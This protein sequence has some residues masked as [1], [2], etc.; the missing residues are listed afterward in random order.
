[1]TTLP[2]TSPRYQFDE[3]KTF[4]Q[5]FVCFI[6]HLR[7]LSKTIKAFFG[8]QSAALSKWL[9]TSP[10]R[11]FAENFFS[12]KVLFLFQHWALSELFLSFLRKFVGPLVSTVF[13]LSNGPVCGE[14][15]FVQFFFLHHFWTLI[16]KW[17]SFVRIFF[18]QVDD[19]AFY[20]S[21]GLIWGLKAV[22]TN[23]CLF[24][25]S[26]ADLESKNQGFFSENNRQGCQNCSPRVHVDILQGFF[27]R[28]VFFIWSLG[29]DRHLSVISTKNCRSLCQYCF[30]FV[31]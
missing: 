4:W 26:F 1:M 18:G 22:L 14:K 17:S 29:I 21:K 10:M 2:F 20:G 15:K 28:K 31:S 6:Y 5:I 19:T 27:F 25:L 13:C 7:T 24:Y 8:K 23:F 12:E 16:A 11:F 3:R 9:S 30:L